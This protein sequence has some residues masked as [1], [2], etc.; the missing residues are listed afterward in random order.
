MPKEKVGK[1]EG[2]EAVDVFDK[3]GQFV[4]TYDVELHGERMVEYAEEY[5]KKIG[6]TVKK[7][8]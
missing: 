6:G 3:D 5:A 8:A 7:H 2:A 1:V 4:R